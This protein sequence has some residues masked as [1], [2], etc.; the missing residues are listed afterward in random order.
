MTVRGGF[1]CLNRDAV[2]AE[3]FHDRAADRFAGLDRDQ[4]NIAAA[5][6]ILLYQ[7]SDIGDK[8]EPVVLDRGER[9]FLDRVPAARGQKEKAAFAS[10]IRRFVQLLGE[11]NERN[12]KLVIAEAMESVRDDLHTYGLADL[13]GPDS[14]FDTVD[15]AVAAFRQLPAP[16]NG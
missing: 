15:E 3:N 5:I 14:I 1:G 8:H 11:I 2:L 9:F 6:G 16:D 10:S 7:D 13:L 4:K 12:I